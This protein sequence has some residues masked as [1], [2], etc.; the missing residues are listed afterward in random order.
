LAAGI[1]RRMPAG[2]YRAINQISR[3]SHAQFR[4]RAPKALGGWSF[5]CDLRDSI[6]RE[7]CFTGRY[8]PQET[9]LVQAI[10]EP[11]MS[12]IDVGANWGYF[13]LLAAHQVGNTGTVVS[14]EPDPRLFPVLTENIAIN[15]FSQVRAL[16]AAAGDGTGLLTLAGFEERG[17]NFGLSRVVKSSRSD[18][19]VFQVAARS[20]DSIFHDLQLGTV[21]LLKMDI[22]GAE[23]LAL[24]GLRET[25]AERRVRRILLELHPAQLAEHGHDPIDIVDQLRE[26][27]Y[28]AWQIDHSQRANRRAAYQKKPIDLRRVLQALE[29]KNA[30]TLD[31]WPHLLLVLRGMEPI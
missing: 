6:A 9:A 15:R 7:V 3:G 22:E 1:I 28:E 19:L 10:L 2:R 24:R 27:G 20:L 14:L 12:F 30:A 26:L 16:Q 17:G 23:G 31:Q 13:T 4:M 5:R 8:E 29:K 25:L 18:A 11:G 21:D